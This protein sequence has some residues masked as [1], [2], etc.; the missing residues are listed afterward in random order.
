MA[1]TAAAMVC[2]AA[3]SLL[4]R[5]ALGEGRLD[6]ATFTLVRLLT[7]ALALHAL[8]RVR[9]RPAPERGSWAGMLAL[10]GYAVFFTLAYTRIGAGVGALVLFGSVQVTMIG[11]GL[12]RGERPARVDWLGVALAA[13]G[14]LVFAPPGATAPDPIGVTLMVAAG[15]CWGAYSLRGRAS[16]DPLGATAGNFAGAAVVGVLFALAGASWRHVTPVGL[17]MAAASGAI[18]SGLGYTIWY[19]ALPAL[20]A[21]RAAVVQLV[22]PVLTALAATAWLRER[23]TGRLMLATALIAL[24]VA[25]TALPALHRARAGR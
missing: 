3:N 9:P 15:A 17:A 16:R 18:A 21:W 7:G 11:A 10:A 13:A 8:T 4:T 22:V 25:L 19:A 23:V 6:A 14:L 1:L 24:G 20:T 12:V 5:G 2:F